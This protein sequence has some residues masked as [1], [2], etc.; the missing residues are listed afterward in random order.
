VIPAIYGKNVIF[1]ESVRGASHKQS[2]KPCQDSHIFTHIE[3]RFGHSYIL[4]VADG[5][6]SE[7][8]PNSKNGS[9]LAVRAF[10]KIMEE[11]CLSYEG[12]MDSLHTFL[13]REG[14]TK[15]A[16]EIETEWKLRVLKTHSDKMRD[17]SLDED[18]IYMQY[19][20]TLAGLLV[21]PGF[22]FA[23]QLGDGDIVFLN[24]SGLEPVITAD[25]ILGT[26][27]H[28]LSQANAW[29][30]AISATKRRDVDE[31]APYAF[32]LST[33]GF[34]NSHASNEE[35][36]K[37]CLEYYAMIN[38]HGA[39]EVAKH[40]KKWLEETSEMGCGDD[41]SVMFF[42]AGVNDHDGAEE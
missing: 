36:E 31:G 17:V 6:G 7:A 11:Y 40:L 22:V 16:Q 13:S 9:L 14:E 4:T 33:D 42:A 2:G 37:S 25:R 10:F 29:R 21:T 27:T 41:V 12:N 15:V 35:Y 24:D 26:E 8:C 34:V 32:M 30:K 5:H 18:E 23:F 28:S 1:G 19:G 20:S 38:E 3:T 39:L